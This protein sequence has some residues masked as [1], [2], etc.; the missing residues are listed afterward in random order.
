M[1]FLNAIGKLVFG[2]SAAPTAAADPFNFLMEEYLRRYQGND[3]P[4]LAAARQQFPTLNAAEARELLQEVVAGYKFAA[5]RHYDARDGK[6]TV[7]QADHDIK[8][9]LPQLRPAT[10]Q[11]LLAQTKAGAY[12]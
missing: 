10:L 2:Q 6:L 7:E 9:H 12:R 1:G 4:L 5:A 3:A 11:R 8:T